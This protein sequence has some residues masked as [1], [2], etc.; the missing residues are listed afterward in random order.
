MQT[1]TGYSAGALPH[2]G[3]WSSP[4][5][6]RKEETSSIAT[7]PIRC[8][9]AHAWW[10]LDRI[11]LWDITETDAQIVHNMKQR[12]HGTQK[13]QGDAAAL[14]SFPAELHTWLKING[15]DR[16]WQQRNRKQKTPVQPDKIYAP[17]HCGQ[18]PFLNR[19][20][21][22]RTGVEGNIKDGLADKCDESSAG[23][24]LNI[25]HGPI[26]TDFTTMCVV[27]H[28]TCGYEAYDTNCLSRCNGAKCSHS[29]PTQGTEL[30]E[31]LPAGFSEAKEGCQVVWD[32]NFTHRDQRSFGR[33]AGD[34]EEVRGG[35]KARGHGAESNVAEEKV[36]ILSKPYYV[37]SFN[38]RCWTLCLCCPTGP[39]QKWYPSI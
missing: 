32:Y 39:S 31:C 26:S 5:G 3:S 37:T 13:I 4:Q 20:R 38:W 12:T 27:L 36:H 34:R 30:S 19:C 22:K 23:L 2:W 14:A 21:N 15:S 17:S 8:R 9:V 28:C 6:K 1:S 16:Q 7:F 25:Y 10:R 18:F 33:Q 35:R 29:S 11:G 24:I